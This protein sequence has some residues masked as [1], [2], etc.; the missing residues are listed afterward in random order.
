MKKAK[1]LK[2]WLKARNK[3]HDRLFQILAIGQRNGD[4]QIKSIGNTKKMLK[5]NIKDGHV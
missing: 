1:R 2:K 4:Y 5:Q 3:K